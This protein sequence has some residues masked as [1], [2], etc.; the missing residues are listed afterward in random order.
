MKNRH[1]KKT[2]AVSMLV[3]FVLLSAEAARGC[4][5]NFT[6]VNSPAEAWAA[7]VKDFDGATAVF[8]GEVVELDTFKVKFRVEKIWKGEAADEI[9]MLTGAIDNGDGT[10]TTSS[11]DYD[12]NKGEKYL[13]YAYGAADELK[14]RVCSR[15]RT[16]EDAEKA[17]EELDLI[18]PHEQRTP[19]QNPQRP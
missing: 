18:W 10:A 15:T 5:C 9:T 3:A 17:M 8:S 2:V 14:T 16:L 12:F 13:V 11:C 6:P 1:M 7:H 4:V 19:P